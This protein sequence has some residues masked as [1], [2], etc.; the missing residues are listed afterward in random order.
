MASNTISILIKAQDNASKVIKDVGDNIDGAGRKSE[1]SAKSINSL[2]DHMGALAG[3]TATA[4]VATY[5][6]IGMMDR[7]ISSANKY[8]AALTGLNSVATAFGH[9]AGRAE[10]AAQSLAKDGLMTV[11]DAAIGL[12]NLLASGFSLDQATTLMKRFKD[13]A[14]FG[15]QS[16]LSFGQAV[17]SATEGIKNGNSILVDNAGVTKNLSNMLTEAGYSAQD[18]SKATT[19]VGIRQA[20]FNGILK[21]TNAQ[22]GDA[23]KLAD[24]A[25]GKQAVWAAQTEILNQKIGMALQPALLSLLQ[26]MTPIITSIA[27]W[28]SQNPQLAAG[29]V[30]GTTAVVGLTTVVGT[31]AL[32]VAGLGPVF[33]LFKFASIA[34]I[35]AVGTGMTGLAALV[36]SPL[37]M[38]AIAVAAAAGAL[39]LVYDAAVKARNAVNEATAAKANLASQDAK[40]KATAYS[41]LNSPA[42]AERKA[43]AQR[44]LNNIA[45]RGNASG[46]AYSPG[47]STLV[48]EN[49]PEIVNM[50]RGSQVTPAY[51]TRNELASDGS[52]GVTNILNGNFT[53]Q[54]AEAVQEFFNRLDKTQ[55]LA[56][57]GM[58]S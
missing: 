30:I 11:T 19:D 7:S 58:A 9:D 51:R 39:F 24:S 38:P 14:A 47:G 40:D 36:A 55:R 3:V 16:A 25:A 45:A 26:T 28:V 34:A 42:S 15:R 10:Q 31:L 29:L 13:S 49:G 48:G 44:V 32:A 27:D 37:A 17:S 43:A 12:K 53:F 23:A 1:A 41:V 20:L 21:E 35:G 5:S 2:N 57:F 52:G 54:S 18:L 4:G 50:P 22:S 46:T 6:L 8:Q 56:K 33:A